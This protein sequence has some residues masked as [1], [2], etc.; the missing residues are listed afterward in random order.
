MP[1]LS[2]QV[3]TISPA[4]LTRGGAPSRRRSRTGSRPWSRAAGGATG[5]AEL[6][7]VNLAR[8]VVD[9]RYVLAAAGMLERDHPDRAAALVRDVL[10][11]VAQP[12]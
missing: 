11:G 12:V 1:S 9:G 2:I 5:D 8:P 6:A 3:S 4:T 7:A 10:G